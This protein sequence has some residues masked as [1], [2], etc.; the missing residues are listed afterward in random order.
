MPGDA[1]NQDYQTLQEKLT[2]TAP[3]VSDRAW[4]HKY[5]HM[6]F[7]DILDDYHNP[8]YQ[9][10]H[11]IKLLQ[12]PVQGDG[13]YINAGRFVAVARELDMPVNI[14]TKILNHRNGKPYRYWRIGTSIAAKPR[15]RWD[16][17]REGNCVAIGWDKIG[18]DLSGITRSRESKERLRQILSECYDQSPQATGRN[19]Q[20]VFNFVAVISEGDLVVAMDGASVLGI[21]RIIGNYYFEESASDFRHRRPVDWLSF[22]EWT[23]DSAEGLR[24]VVHQLR[25]NDSNLVEV[26]RKILET[27]IQEIQ[28]VVKKPLH[29]LG[30]IEG[31]I[32][33]ILERKNQV[34][35]YGPPG[36]GK[37]YWARRVAEELAARYNFGKS[38][39]QLSPHESQSITDKT[40]TG[41]GFA[42]LCSFHPAYGYEDFIEG[43]RP[44]VVGEHVGFTLQDG[45]FKRICN[46]A[47][48]DP[49]KRY[50]LIIDE[51]NRGD[52]PRIFGE[53][54]TVIEKDKRSTPIM[55]P[56][57]KELL[58]VPLN[59]FIIGTMNTADRS[60]SLLD[61]A[62]RRRFG[63]I[64]LM[65]DI[66][67]L[68]DSSIR[69]IPLG[70]WLE[71]LNKRIRD[72]I[73][74]DARNLQ[75]GHSY[76]LEKG[77]PITDF[78]KFIRIIQDDVIPLLEEYCYEDYD[79][80]EKILGEGIVDSANLKIKEELFLEH[81]YDELVQALLTPAREISA[82]A[83]AIRSESE[84]R[85]TESSEEDESDLE[86]K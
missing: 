40:S 14:V 9:R 15:D 30:G 19:T 31:K 21:G 7:P 69:G 79:T 67:L 11:L 68:G 84:E 61:T 53:L 45:V 54:M 1:T 64:E 83:R 6:L 18:T 10:F 78:G 85:E 75:I 62:L 28:A 55:L 27:N 44:T 70:L 39:D 51:I 29:R 52:I 36:T 25:K 76:F 60:I 80:L 13:R 82:S 72:N 35:L 42:W 65:P 26:E 86:D 47:T 81:N 59:L 48:K 38:F 22:E 56:L 32:Q 33:S 63:F 49:G 58:V 17:M 43:F 34:I 66:S 71:A 5:F 57:S 16:I 37:T 20:Q 2:H 73:G 12:K 24:R 46:A 50:F 74:R 77:V 8:D 23:M 4:G 41:G 3:D